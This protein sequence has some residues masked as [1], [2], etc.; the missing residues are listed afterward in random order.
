[1]PVQN[2]KRLINA[3]AF[4]NVGHI[5]EFHALMEQQ[6]TTADR[7]K[8]RSAERKVGKTSAP[9]VFCVVPKRIPQH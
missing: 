8:A 7:A 9:V 5:S 6:E 4:A 2:F 3:L 1:M